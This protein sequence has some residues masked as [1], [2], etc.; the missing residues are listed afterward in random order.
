MITDAIKKSPAKMVKAP[1]SPTELSPA[2]TTRKF[3]PLRSVE[4]IKKDENPH[5]ENNDDPASAVKSKLQ[6]LG[7]LYSGKI[8]ARLVREINSIV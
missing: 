2:K 7:K 6:R 8:S 1:V 5:K 4:K 3:S